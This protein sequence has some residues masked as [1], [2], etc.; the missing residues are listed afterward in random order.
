MIVIINLYW[1]YALSVTHVSIIKKEK[2]SDNYAPYAHASNN[3]ELNNFG[4][5]LFHAK[6][7]ACFCVLYENLY[8]VAILTLFL[9]QSQISQVPPVFLLLPT[10]FDPTT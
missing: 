2:C 1:L 6:E 3:I 8:N 9:P 5:T 4:C 10:S 7:S